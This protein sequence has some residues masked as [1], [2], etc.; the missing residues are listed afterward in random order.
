MY[1]LK[2][3]IGSDGCHKTTDSDIY[4]DVCNTVLLVY[5]SS[6]SLGL[7]AKIKYGNFYQCPLTPFC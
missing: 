4:V 1:V 6:T 7:L 2:H 3:V 5:L